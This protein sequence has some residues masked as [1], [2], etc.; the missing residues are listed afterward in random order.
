MEKVIGD[1][2]DGVFFSRHKKFSSID[3]VSDS[4]VLQ[5]IE[6]DRRIPAVFDLIL[7]VTDF[8][9]I[10]VV[11]PWNG[12]CLICGEHEIVTL[13]AFKSKLDDFRIWISL[14]SFEGFIHH[15]IQ[16]CN[17]DVTVILRVESPSLTNKIF[18]NS[19]SVFLFLYFIIDLLDWLV[20][21]DT[22]LNLVIIF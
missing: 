5:V 10:L 15:I 12:V 21:K 20:F 6:N 8:L 2:V 14:L 9:P 13:F 22:Q 3:L 16:E 19:M 1:V 4:H 11:V 7:F 18:K 17:G